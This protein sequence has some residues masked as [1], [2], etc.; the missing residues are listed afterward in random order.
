MWCTLLDIFIEIKQIQQHHK[1]NLPLVAN[2]HNDHVAVTMLPRILQPGGQVV[3]SLSP[4]DVV[5]KQCAGSATVVR[6]CD[7]TESLL[8]RGVPDLQLDLLSVYCDHAR[9]KLYTY[10]QRK[11]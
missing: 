2:E 3:E 4:C 6:P 11:I 5:H 7:A 1:A 9:T 8:A 10:W